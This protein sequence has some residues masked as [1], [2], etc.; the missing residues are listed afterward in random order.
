[1]QFLQV[2]VGQKASKEDVKKVL[3]AGGFFAGENPVLDSGEFDKL[4]RF[5]TPVGGDG[6]MLDPAD[7]EK[8]LQGKAKQIA[9][10]L[11]SGLNPLQKRRMISSIT[12]GMK[13]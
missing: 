3:N 5:V 12:D 11:N 6:A 8:L 7:R 2:Q 9:E 1:M 13:G 4:W 10:V